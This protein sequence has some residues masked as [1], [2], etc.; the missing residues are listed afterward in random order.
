MLIVAV[1]TESNLEVKTCF[2]SMSITYTS[3]IVVLSL[4]KVPEVGFGEAVNLLAA[5]SFVPNAKDPS[6]LK[7]PPVFS[8][9]L[10]PA[11]HPVVP[12]KNCTAPLCSGA[13][14]TV[15]VAPLSLL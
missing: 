8:S 4:D 7:I 15:Q 10:N 2:P 1:F 3:E 14:N 5:K 13:P 9:V 11:L 6:N 12:L